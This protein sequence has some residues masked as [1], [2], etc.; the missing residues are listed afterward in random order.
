METGEQQ[1]SSVHFSPDVCNMKDMAW[2]D[3][4]GLIVNAGA[5]HGAGAELADTVVSVSYNV[6][7]Q[8]F[9]T[10]SHVITK[11]PFR[12]RFGPCWGLPH[13]TVDVKLKNGVVLSGVF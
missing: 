5:C 9:R 10:D 2:R 1:G 12:Q 11:P 8:G 3:N 13:V 4:Q 6:P 7:G